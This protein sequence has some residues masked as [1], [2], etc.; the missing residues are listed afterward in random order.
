MMEI[1]SVNGR[2]FPPDSDLKFIGS[3]YFIKYLLMAQPVDQN[4][5]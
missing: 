2:F 4:P 3:I 1:I 5:H